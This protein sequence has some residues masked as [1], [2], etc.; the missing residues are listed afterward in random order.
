MAYVEY[1]PERRPEQA[2]VVQS[3]WDEKDI[4]SQVPG[5]NWHGRDTEKFWAGPI[6]WASYVVLSQVFAND[7]QLGPQFTDWV[8]NDYETRV[9]PSMS[10][11]GLLGWPETWPRDGWPERVSGET[12]ELFDFQDVDALWLATAQDAALCNDMG[13]GKT[14]SLLA[15]LK[16][17]SK[18]HG[19]VPEGILPL[20]LI[21][22]NGVKRH[23]EKRVP[24]WF[25]QATPYIVPNTGPVGRAKLLDKAKNDPT[26]FVICNIEAVRLVSR[27]TGYGNVALKRCK[28]CDPRGG[29][30]TPVMTKQVDDDGNVVLGDD[31]K[32][33]MVP[34]LDENGEPVMKPLP[35]SSCEVH[36]KPFQGFGFRMAVI[37]EAHRIRN[38]TSKS[39]RAVWATFH[40]PSVQRHV[41]LTGTPIAQN[42]GD[43]WAIM[44]AVAPLEYPAKS[45]Y[46]DRY[47]LMTWDVGGGMNIAGVR[48][49]R[50]DELFT[51]RKSVV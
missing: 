51:D 31:G 8:K 17:L 44:H 48:P 33:V 2:L 37:D 11:R 15:A 46:I 14:V 12:H 20:V 28:V 24:E 1:H 32:P 30:E 22:P 5:F 10:L 3:R 45:K 9:Y 36:P 49:D 40:D 47:A 23:W 25:P 34:V 29:I 13:T 19:T 43:L 27:L 50:R 7:L 6:S 39:T 4:I 21:C 42:M 41:A 26:A 35:P 16:L 18:L 38:P